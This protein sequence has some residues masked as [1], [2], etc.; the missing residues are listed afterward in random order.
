MWMENG[1]KLSKGD[2]VTRA[3]P[4]E[5]VDRIWD[6]RLREEIDCPVHSSRVRKEK[7]KILP[8]LEPWL[9]MRVNINDLKSD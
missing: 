5:A 7:D 4:R 1:K 9:A 2:W 6:S 8:F 3:E